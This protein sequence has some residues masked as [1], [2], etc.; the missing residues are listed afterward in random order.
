MSVT[1]SRTGALCFPHTAWACP[2]ELAAHSV[3]LVSCSDY[4]HFADSN[5]CAKCFLVNLPADR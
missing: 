4:G 3:G 2:T 5:Q 1:V